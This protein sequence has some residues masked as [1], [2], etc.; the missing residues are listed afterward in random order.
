MQNNL[1]WI[2]NNKVNKSTAFTQE[3]KQRL[4]LEGL[5]PHKTST[6]DLQVNRVLQNLSKKPNDIEKYLY[7]SALQARNE[8]LF[9][10]V[11]NDHIEDL[12]P[13]IYTPTVGEA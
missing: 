4:G 8:R 7:L 13:I 2:L 5:F 6:Q 12:L 10:R 9:Y 3:E 11:L 1:E